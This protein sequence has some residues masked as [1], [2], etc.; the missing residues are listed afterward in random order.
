[1]LGYFIFYFHFFKKKSVFRFSEAPE[2]KA[3]SIGNF[4]LAIVGFTMA[5]ISV[6]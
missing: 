4:F 3:V 2:Q 5:K 1:L 6:F